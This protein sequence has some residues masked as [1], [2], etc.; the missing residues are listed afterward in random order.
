MN[1]TECGCKL[2]SPEERDMKMCQRCADEKA[3][4]QEISDELDCFRDGFD[5]D[6]YH[7]M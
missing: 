7:H 5:E 2:S 6:S 1:C 4:R 3:T